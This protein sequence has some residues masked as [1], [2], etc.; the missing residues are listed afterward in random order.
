MREQKARLDYRGEESVEKEL[1]DSALT[2]RTHLK[3]L[4]R[5][6]LSSV[7]KSLDFSNL[8]LD[9]IH[10]NGIK[11]LKHELN[12]QILLAYVIPNLQLGRN[13]LARISSKLHV[14]WANLHRNTLDLEKLNTKIIYAKEVQKEL[15]SQFASALDEFSNIQGTIQVG[16]IHR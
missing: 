16:I 5:L 14:P 8:C 12:E 1:A 7:T 3:H 6:H 2:S 15:L 10:G 9:Q 4:D 11:L 13:E